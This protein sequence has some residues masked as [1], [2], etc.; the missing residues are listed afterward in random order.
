MALRHTFEIPDRFVA[1]SVGDG[2][3]RSY[4]LQV[5]QDR[6]ILTM[7]CEPAQLEALALHCDRV[8]DEVAALPAGIPIPPRVTTA[9]DHDP[10]DVPLERDFVVGTM[11]VGW[12]PL[13][14]A[15]QLDLFADTGLPADVDPTLTGEELA[16]REA[17]RTSEM[18]VVLLDPD[19]GRE[20]AARTR[21]VLAAD[22]PTCPA[23]SQPIRPTGHV[24]PRRNGYLGR[25][26][27][28]PRPGE[29]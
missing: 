1:G 10:L 13:L 19:Q 28:H 2:E 8:L 22:L 29:Y 26:A 17:A 25:S 24:C 6:R 23:C 3:D 16:A 20:F 27:W 5:R 14:R 21:A 11:A 18:A 9:R 12:D 4:V 15:L 7:P